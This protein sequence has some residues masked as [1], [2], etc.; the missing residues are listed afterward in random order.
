MVLQLTCIFAGSEVFGFKFLKVCKMIYSFIFLWIALPTES[1]YPKNELA[2][3]SFNILRSR[4]RSS[5]G[6]VG[7]LE[8][9]SAGFS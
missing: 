9:L 4:G 3:S 1:K 2:E 7:L 5:G 8:L 6:S